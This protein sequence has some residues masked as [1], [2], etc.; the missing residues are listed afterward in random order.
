MTLY[1][2][3]VGD[4]L[5]GLAAEKEDGLGAYVPGY[6]GNHYHHLI[7]SGFGKHHCEQRWAAITLNI[8]SGIQ[9]IDQDF[10]FDPKEVEIVEFVSNA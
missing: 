1:A 3:R 5:I 7:I 8:Q 4:R 10:P 6:D 9:P 2:F